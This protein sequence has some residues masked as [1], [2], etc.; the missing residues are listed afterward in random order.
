[1]LERTLR[2]GFRSAS[3]TE[4]EV[5]LK[6]FADDRLFAKGDSQIILSES[7]FEAAIRL[8]KRDAKS[9]KVLLEQVLGSRDASYEVVSEMLHA[10]NRFLPH[11]QWL[12]GGFIFQAILERLD[13]DNRERLLNRLLFDGESNFWQLKWFLEP[14]LVSNILSIEYLTQFFNR[15][16]S[17]VGQDGA[18]GLYYELIHSYVQAMPG[19][20]IKMLSASLKDEEVETRYTLVIH[21]VGTLRKIDLDT[22]VAK[23]FQLIE[24]SLRTSS[25]WEWRS[26]WYRSWLISVVA[27][28]LKWEWLQGLIEPIL[29]E[30]TERLD[31]II[32]LCTAFVRSD[33]TSDTFVLSVLK[34]LDTIDWKSVSS[35]GKYTFLSSIGSLLFNLRRSNR[36]DIAKF[37]SLIFCK[38]HPID[39]KELGVWSVAIDF[40]GHLLKID[41]SSFEVALDAILEGNDSESI[42]FILEEDHHLFHNIKR[43]LTDTSSVDLIVSWLVRPQRNYRALGLS[44]FAEIDA[45]DMD[46]AF[47]QKVSD[48]ALQ[49]ALYTIILENAIG[50]TVSKYLAFLRPAFEGRSSRVVSQ[51]Q[52]DLFFNGLN[53]P[54]TC[55]ESWRKTFSSDDAIFGPVF[56]TLDN[57]LDPHAQSYEDGWSNLNDFVPEGIELARALLKERWRTRMAESEKRAMVRHP[58]LSLVHKTN[59]LY[60]DEFS[61]GIEGKY[62]RSAPFMK[63]ESSFEPPKLYLIDPE[64]YWIRFFEASDAE[65]KIIGRLLERK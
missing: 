62:S 50:P 17:S 24:E 38:I 44:L 56:K 42:R 41:R 64:R 60:G 32:Y 40:I 16:I 8:L 22:E 53:Y 35:N 13:L 21:I 52:Q 4:L 55:F 14:V 58:L 19:D 18:A 28:E 2:I 1:M 29:N 23:E 6:V 11:S 49:L 63:S 51:Y 31:E 57:C 15:C 34:F 27:R 26:V 25:E 12:L 30:T 9:R 5:I 45:P 43:S 48:E 47:W 3:M 54:G 46:R 10:L 7:N 20:A 33:D 36:C 65:S 39:T 37:A 61:S 59:I